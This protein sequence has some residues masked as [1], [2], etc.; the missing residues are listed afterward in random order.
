ML[1]LPVKH[2]RLTSKNSHAQ[3]WRNQVLLEE[4]RAHGTW[5]SMI[6]RS[7]GGLLEATGKVRSQVQIP[8]R[9]RWHSVQAER[10]SMLTWSRSALPTSSVYQ[11]KDSRPDR[12]MSDVPAKF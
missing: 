12:A 11:L 7:F 5:F 3:T 1:E 10:H 6:H 2:Q 4:G 9:Q 8:N